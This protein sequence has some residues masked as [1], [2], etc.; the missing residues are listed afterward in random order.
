M[1]WKQIANKKYNY[2]DNGTNNIDIIIISMIF[3]TYLY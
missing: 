3:A 2:D 1:L